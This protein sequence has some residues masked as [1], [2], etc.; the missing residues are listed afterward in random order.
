MGGFVGMDGG[1]VRRALMDG[2][3]GRAF[4]LEHEGQALAVPLAHDHHDAPLAGLVHGQATIYAVN[5]TVGGLH[6]AAEVGAI[7]LDVAL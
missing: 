1:A 3:D 7:D 6:V 4:G 5:L 2:R